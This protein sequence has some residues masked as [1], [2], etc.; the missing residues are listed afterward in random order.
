MQKNMAFFQVILV[1]HLR[2]L[3]EARFLEMVVNWFI[4][5]ERAVISSYVA[6]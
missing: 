6:T 1:L 5:L 4:N 3:C 2:N